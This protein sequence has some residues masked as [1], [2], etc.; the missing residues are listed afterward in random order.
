MILK[1]KDTEKIATSAI[2]ETLIFVSVPSANG[3]EEVSSLSTLE[4]NNKKWDKY[5]DKIKRV[6]VDQ[7]RSLKQTMQ[8][9]ESTHGFKA[10]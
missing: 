5:K 4:R 10:R 1:M 8:L 3:F 2:G 6:Y 9:M 7:D